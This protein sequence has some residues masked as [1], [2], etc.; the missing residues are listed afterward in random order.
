MGPLGSTVEVVVVGEVDASATDRMVVALT[1]AAATRSV[2]VDLSG[3]TFVDT[4]ILGIV[5]RAR[6]RVV[7]Q[8]GTLSIHRPSPLVRRRLELLGLAGLIEPA[9][10]AEG[11]ASLAEPAPAGLQR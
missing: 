5:A 6:E 2:A 1:V 3:V 4:R 8:G 11:S 7:L 10:A 9:L